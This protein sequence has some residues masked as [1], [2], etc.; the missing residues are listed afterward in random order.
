MRRSGLVNRVKMETGGAE[1]RRAEDQG[2][3]FL[4]APIRSIN[5][6]TGKA[7]EIQSFLGRPAEAKTMIT[8]PSSSECGDET[9][10]KRCPRGRDRIL[11]E[12]AQTAFY[13]RRRIASSRQDAT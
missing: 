12:P 10:G 11:Y 1:E 8:K 13:Q 9:R 7:A 6:T 5:H 3:A 4:A 2:V